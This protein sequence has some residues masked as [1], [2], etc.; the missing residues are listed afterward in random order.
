[1]PSITYTTNMNLAKPYR[2]MI[3]WDDE[4]NQNW[5]D[6][7]A[8]I[9]T[10]KLNIK[11]LSSD[12][13]KNSS[14]VSL[15]ANSD[16]S[17]I[18]TVGSGN[19][20]NFI[21]GDVVGI[22]CDGLAEITRT[23]QS[24]NDGA[25][26]VTMTTVVP[27]GYTMALSASVYR[28]TGRTNGDGLGTLAEPLESASMFSKL[29]AY[30]ITGYGQL[31]TVGPG[32]LTKPD[33]QKI[34]AFAKQS[35]GDGSQYAGGG[36]DFSTGVITGGGD[37][38]SPPNIGSDYITAIICLTIYDTLAV[39]FG[40]QQSTYNSA[41]TTAARAIGNSENLGIVRVTLRG[42]GGGGFLVIRRQDCED[43]R[44]FLNTGGVSI[45]NLLDPNKALF[46]RVTGQL[47][48]DESAQIV[49]R[50]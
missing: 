6:I 31:V 32:T 20:S 40:T 50:R 39:T 29:L 47:I 3:D 36:V 23:V 43:C 17:A 1:M 2:G 24:V 22:F 27:S 21:A 41:R 13:Y 45:S 9:T 33:G 4:I 38:F 12:V 48:I 19:T 42:N 18:V 26:T 11:Q 10:N 34:S 44:S 37:S 15:T 5:D 14:P 7:D 28:K 16:G 49:S 46:S 8:G 25:G 30:S 35:P